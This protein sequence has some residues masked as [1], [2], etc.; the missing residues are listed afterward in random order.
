MITLPP[1]PFTATAGPALVIGEVD[2]QEAP[3]GVALDTIIE[4][5]LAAGA[6]VLVHEAC[7]TSAL[8]P[9]IAGTTFETIFDYH[10]DTVPLGA[11]AAR[12]GVPHV[13]LTHLIPPPDRPGDAEAFADD[14]RAGGYQ[15]RITVGDDLTT[16]AVGASRPAAPAPGGP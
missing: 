8:A 4:R 9:A 3:A 13:V 12:T 11:M 5:Q 1:T 16:V 14:L 15:G 10:A 2:G 7:R 6:D